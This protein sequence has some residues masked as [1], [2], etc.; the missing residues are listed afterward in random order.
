MKV[1]LVLVSILAAVAIGI[2]AVLGSFVIAEK[3]DDHDDELVAEEE[4]QVT[5]SQVVWCVNNEADL[6]AAANALDVRFTATQWNKYVGLRQYVGDW[7]G[8]FEMLLDDYAET[9]LAF[10]D[11]VD[12]R[13]YGPTGDDTIYDMKTALREDDE[14]RTVCLAA[15][16]AEFGYP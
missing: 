15:W 11:W 12:A 16:G 13:G 8:A 7:D 10:F 4:A 5:D 3:N 2:A 1:A 14:L 9:R 6:M